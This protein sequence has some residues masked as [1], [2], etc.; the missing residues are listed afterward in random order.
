MSE[1]AIELAT[2]W[3]FVALAGVLALLLVVVASKNVAHALLLGLLLF[4]THPGASSDKVRPK[5]LQWID[6]PF[7]S[8]GFS[9][10]LR[11][12]DGTP[13]L[14][15]QCQPDTVVVGA[16]NRWHKVSLQTLSTD[17]ALALARLGASTRSLGAALREHV[18]EPVK[19]QL[20]PAYANV[21]KKKAEL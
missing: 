9:L 18:V 12:F 19:K 21:G 5:E 6:T 2:V 8:F 1:A 4:A 20:T 15:R 16:L 11:C 14:G 17:L 10:P 13:L 7:A 3:P